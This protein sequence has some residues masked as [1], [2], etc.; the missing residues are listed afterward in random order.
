MTIK[1]NGKGLREE[2]AQHGKRKNRIGLIGMRERVEMVQ[3]TFTA[4]SAR[5]KG[6]AVLAQ[7]PV[8]DAGLSNRYM[9]SARH[10]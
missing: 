1:D 3:G 6:T 7:I 4:R 8:S 10:P 9:K 5:G 2:H